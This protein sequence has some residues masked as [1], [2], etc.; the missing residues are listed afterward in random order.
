MELIEDFNNPD[1]KHKHYK[2]HVAET[3]EDFYNSLKPD[4]NGYIDPKFPPIMSEDD[5]EKAANDLA[6]SSTGLSSDTKSPIIGFKIK[7][8]YNNK[9]RDEKI[10]KTSKYVNFNRF[11]SHN[12]PP[13]MDVVVYKIENEKPVIISFMLSKSNKIFR[14]LKF[15]VDELEENKLSIEKALEKLKNI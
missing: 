5:Y 8:K 13:L 11:K 12:I 7:D 4:N 2:K 10:R 9:T 1:V 15:K 3:W 6:L 14:E